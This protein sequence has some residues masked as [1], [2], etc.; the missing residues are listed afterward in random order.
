[1]KILFSDH[2]PDL[3]AV[4]VPT[5]RFFRNKTGTTFLKT[6][7]GALQLDRQLIYFA[8]DAAKDLGDVDILP[9]DFSVTLGGQYVAV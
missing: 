1:M 7:N 9:K 4:T 3:T 5:G 2:V 8:D 6:W